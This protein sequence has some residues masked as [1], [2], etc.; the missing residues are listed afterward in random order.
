[1]IVFISGKYYAPARAERS[2]FSKLIDRSIGLAY[3]LRNCTR[4][5]LRSA[6]HGQGDT[7]E[8]CNNQHN[9]SYRHNRIEMQGNNQVSSD[10]DAYAGGTTFPLLFNIT[11]RILNICRGVCD[12]KAQQEIHDEATLSENLYEGYA[13]DLDFAVHPMLDKYGNL[14]GATCCISRLDTLIQNLPKTATGMTNNFRRIHRMGV[15][16][17]QLVAILCIAPHHGT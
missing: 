2:G 6:H 15:R 11:R 5:C 3:D 9:V 14:Q 16:Y 10:Y 17:D 13:A 7:D 1:M 12:E 4:R 8:N